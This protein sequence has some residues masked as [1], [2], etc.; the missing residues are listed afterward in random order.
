MFRKA[1]LDVEAWPI[2]DILKRNSSWYAR[3]GLF[4]E[5]VREA[6]KCGWYRWQGWI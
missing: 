1:G 3:Q 5:L 2:P 4:V 6:A